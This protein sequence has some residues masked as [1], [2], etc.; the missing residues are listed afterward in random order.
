MISGNLRISGND[1]REKTS[2][3]KYHGKNNKEKT[4]EKKHH[5]KNNKEKTSRKEHQSGQTLKKI[6]KG[7][8]GKKR[9]NYRINRGANTTA[10]IVMSL[11]RMLIAGPAV[12]L[13]GS[14]TVSPVT[15]AMWAPEPFPP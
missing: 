9:G 3:K 11:M 14:P 4:S 8:K 7:K 1:S 13:K 2:E 6:K 10:T 12:S 15:P 5:G